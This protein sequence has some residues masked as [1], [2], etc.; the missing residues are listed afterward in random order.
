MPLTQMPKVEF[1]MDG[2]EG[3]KQSRWKSKAVLNALEGV[4]RK[5]IFNHLRTANNS[6]T[7]SKKL[8]I[9]NSTPNIIIQNKSPRKASLS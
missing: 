5:E 7:I 4:K 2:D 6:S 1:E 8:A 3:L 9:L